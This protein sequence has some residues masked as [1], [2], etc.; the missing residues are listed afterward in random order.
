M[1]GMQKIKR[2][3][4]FRGLLEYLF[5]NKDGP[6]PGRLIG[7]TM[8]SSNPRDLAAEFKASRRLRPDVAKP[9]WHNALR[10]PA[11]E[12]VSD[13]I[14]GQIATRYLKLMGYDISKTQTCLVKH[15][16]EAAIH[17]AASRIQ[18]DGSLY[19]GEN[20]NLKSTRI[21]QQLEH[22]F[23]LTITKGPE[24]G[25]DGK[26][27][28]PSQRAASK[29]E[30]EAALRTQT[31]PP[32]ERLKGMVTEALADH[33]SLPEF[34]RRLE[35]AGVVVKANI[36][37]TG[38]MNG[39]SF[40]LEGVAFKGSQLG[41]QFKWHKLKDNLNYDEI[42]DA[43][44]LEGLGAKPLTGAVELASANIRAANRNLQAAGRTL[45][46]V[47]AGAAQ[48]HL[49]I[50]R[51]PVHPVLEE[52]KREHHGR[53]GARL[54]AARSGHRNQHLRGEYPRAFTT[55][56]ND[57]SANPPGLRASK[58][59]RSQ[60][61]PVLSA[62][63]PRQGRAE[64]RDPVLP[65]AFPGLGNRDR[66]LHQSY[67]NLT[68]GR[69]SNM[70]D[71][72][73]FIDCAEGDWLNRQEF[74]A[75]LLE[76]RYQK[77][78]SQLLQE[79]L[80]FVDL[81]DHQIRIELK[82]GAVVTDKG[83]TMTSTG[84]DLQTV[85]S[86]IALAQTKGWQRISAKGSPEFLRLLYQEAQAAG[87]EIADPNA[88]ELPPPAEIREAKADNSSTPRPTPTPKWVAPVHKKFEEV[89]GK[90]DE[91]SSK[92][93]ELAG[94]ENLDEVRAKIVQQHADSGYRSAAQRLEEA[95]HRAESIGS[96]VPF[97]RRAREQAVKQAKQDLDAEWKRVV[98]AHGQQV[99]D[100]KARNEERQ[101]LDSEIFRLQTVQSDIRKNLQDPPAADISLKNDWAARKMAYHPHGPWKE[102]EWKGEIV[103]PMLDEE[104]RQRELER[105]QELKLLEQK[106]EDARY[107][108]MRLEHEI[109]LVEEGMQSLDPDDQESEEYRSAIA[110]IDK[111]SK[112]IKQLE[113][114]A[115]L[116][117]DE[118]EYAPRGPRL[119]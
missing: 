100:A 116:D 28:L 58:R 29:N 114:E 32:R 67:P 99:L 87:L 34:K 81:Q 5:A 64:T 55:W 82:T 33:P 20:E 52:K 53:T 115:G 106:K 44:Q 79:Q 90:I 2:G 16:D 110:E 80:H 24:L 30:L 62:H 78:I 93:R 117:E 119:S 76:K 95:K 69:E 73:Q 42:R 15:D 25:P 35:A 57:N 45:E 11:G 83:D 59:A 66:G 13:E 12:D 98:L 7:G 21:I 61:M 63:G 118:N 103:K 37:S 56:R 19:L 75:K 50:T 39:F 10:M 109:T 89:S 111:Y 94:L 9:V 85:R 70:S 102:A 54:P 6:A 104:E 97:L 4:G 68:R 96:A 77:S 26:I 65:N 51:I 3:T 88:P 38:R 71:Q 46:I 101:R 49:N 18:L 92:R 72:D 22:E 47:A 1:K 113:Q 41:D 40:E 74:K 84:E 91:L 36:A 27:I 8:A 108:V 60:R 48:S 23:N 17:I 112:Q 14:W 86:L 105:Q 43:F 31:V 107:E